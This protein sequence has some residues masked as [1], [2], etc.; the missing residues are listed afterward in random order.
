VFIS[1]IMAIALSDSALE[2]TRFIKGGK[3]KSIVPSIGTL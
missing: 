1:K 2:I 3:P